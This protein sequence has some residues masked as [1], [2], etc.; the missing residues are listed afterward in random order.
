MFQ[1]FLKQFTAHEDGTFHNVERIS[2]QNEYTHKKFKS[3]HRMTKIF[4]HTHIIKIFRIYALRGS[5]R[6]TTKIITQKM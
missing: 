1:A 6:K 4:S 2:L 3:I 5:I